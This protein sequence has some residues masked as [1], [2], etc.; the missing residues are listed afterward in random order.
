MNLIQNKID[1]LRTNIIK[2]TYLH[3]TGNLEIDNARGTHTTKVYPV[4]NANFAFTSGALTP[5]TGGASA[6]DTTIA[7]N[8]L[9]PGYYAI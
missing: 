7:F 6:A 9:S 1:V 4:N 2:Y 8:S 5:T 3:T